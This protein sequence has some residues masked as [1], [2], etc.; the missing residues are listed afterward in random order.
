MCLVVSRVA[1]GHG[2]VETNEEKRQV[3]TQAETSVNSELLIELVKLELTAR[4]GLVIA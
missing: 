4:E 1:Y 2:N 3:E